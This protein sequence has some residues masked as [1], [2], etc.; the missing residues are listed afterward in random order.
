MELLLVHNV[1][2][3]F[4]CKGESSFQDA[5]RSDNSRILSMLKAKFGKPDCSRINPQELATE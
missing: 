1:E 5:I 2:M 3:K 4:D